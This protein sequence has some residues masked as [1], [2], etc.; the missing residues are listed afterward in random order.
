MVDYLDRGRFGKPNVVLDSSI[1]HERHGASRANPQNNLSFTDWKRWISF[2]RNGRGQRSSTTLK[3]AI[4][5]PSSHRLLRRRPV[6][7]TRSSFG[8]SSFTSIVRLRSSSSTSWAKLAGQR[9]PTSLTTSSSRSAFLHALTCKTGLILAKAAAM[10]I[11][12]KLEPVCLAPP[13]CLASFC[14]LPNVS[15]YWFS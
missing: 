5:A 1:V 15:V 2:S 11:N 4:S 7:S 12:A 3:T 6:G 13:L 8:S 14:A 10:R 9:S